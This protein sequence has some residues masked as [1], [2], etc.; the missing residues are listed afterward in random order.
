MTRAPDTRGSLH[1]RIEALPRK[2]AVPFLQLQKARQIDDTAL[3]S[4]LDAGELVHD[5]SRLLGFAIAFMYLRSSGV[6]IID[7]IRMAKSQKRRINLAWSASRW[8][9]EHDRL[10]RAETLARLAEQ[11][12][13]YAVTKFEQHLPETFPGYLIRS[14]KRLGMEGLRQRHC[15]ASYH[16][17]LMSGHCAVA[18]LFVDRQRWTVQLFLTGKLDAPLRIGQIKTRFNG[19]PSNEVRSAIFNM[20]GIAQTVQTGGVPVQQPHTYT[21]LDTLQRLLPIL[22]ANNV[23]RVSVWFDGS[24]DS[25]SI[26]EVNFDNQDFNAG[27]TVIEHMQ[28]NRHFENGQWVEAEELTQSSVHEAI[29]ALTYDYLEQAGV[30]WYNDDGGYGDLV[31][32]VDEGTV[33]LDINVR[34]TESSNAFCQ[35]LEIMTGNETP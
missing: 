31:I 32:N 10:S 15:V 34:H 9:T 4:I 1:P 2:I 30:D 6:P 35:E 22:R 3:S 8:K 24:G 26:G 27:N 18:S 17:Q 28:S 29:D 14:S 23:S 13:H 20:L 21:Y 7:V 33:F 25:G 12:V 11:Q 5:A 16:D 19:L